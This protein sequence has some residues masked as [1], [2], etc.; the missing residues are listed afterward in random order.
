MIGWNLTYTAI[1]S[2][3]LFA[4]WNIISFWLIIFIVRKI[5]KI[6]KKTFILQR[7]KLWKIECELFT[8]FFIGSKFQNLQCNATRSLGISWQSLSHCKLMVCLNNVHSLLSLHNSKL[9]ASNTQSIAGRKYSQRIKLNYE[10]IENV[11]NIY[12]MNHESTVYWNR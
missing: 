9:N 2:K 1:D 4:Y 7:S 12:C 11:L 8:L 6:P 10:F 3:L 5:V